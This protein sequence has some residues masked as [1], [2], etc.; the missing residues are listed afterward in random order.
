MVIA[1]LASQEPLRRACTFLVGVVIGTLFCF[2]YLKWFD[3]DNFKITQIGKQLVLPLNVDLFPNLSS[4][5]SLVGTGLS[6]HNMSEIAHAESAL[7]ADAIAKEVRVFCWILTGEANHKTRAMHVKATWLKRCNGYMFGSSV[8]DRQLGA[9]NLGVPE[10]RPFLWRKTM[11]AF[12]LIYEKHLNDYDW[13]LKADDDTYVIVE[14]LRLLL[15]SYKPN[16]PVYLG[17]NLHHPNGQLYMSGGA[18]YVLSR[19]ALTQVVEKVFK[20]DMLSKEM[21]P[22]DLLLGKALKLA[23]VNPS[24]SLDMYGRPRFFP[25][26]P[27]FH[28]R[29]RDPDK[30]FW[31]YSFSQ[32]PM[33]LG[34]S[35]CSDFT[36]SFHYVVPDLMYV[37]EYFIYHLRPFGILHVPFNRLSLGNIS[38]A[39]VIRIASSFAAKFNDVKH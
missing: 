29:Q 33:K 26:S 2:C 13:F 38:H 14:N 35:C 36:I 21:G 8:E 5:D 18:G 27:Q 7:V 28:V 30:K 4:D 39:E 22:E 16:D 1:D 6:D 19:Y 11:K 34:L 32:Y 15:L 17:S 10:G 37:L 3:H 25:L 31:L 23:G 20:K 24:D 9:V 12:S